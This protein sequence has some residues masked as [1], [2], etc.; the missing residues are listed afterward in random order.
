MERPITMAGSA[1][2]GI[3]KVTHEKIKQLAN[4]QPIA[5]YLRDLIKKESES[6]LQSN[7]Q[8][9]TPID[10][11]N[12]SLQETSALARAVAA[13][14]IMGNPAAYIEEF[15]NPGSIINKLL[16]EARYQIQD[17]LDMAAV[18]AKNKKESKETKPLP[19][20]FNGQAVNNEA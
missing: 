17:I 18:W 15:N 10:R 5:Q 6:G 2:V 16:P 13:L 9:E 20:I 3:D 14:L 7:F 12:K 1:S 11:V 8:P 19:G 4:G